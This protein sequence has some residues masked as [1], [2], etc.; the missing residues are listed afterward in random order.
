MEY[1]SNRMNEFPKGKHDDSAE[2]YCIKDLIARIIR[3]YHAD[4]K[5]S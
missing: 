4:I 1:C 3:L 5:R 2:S